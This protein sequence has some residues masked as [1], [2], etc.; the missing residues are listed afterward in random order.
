MNSIGNK[1]ENLK[2]IIRL[3]LDVIAVAETKINAS[4]PKGQL[5]FEEYHS[6]YSLDISRKI[7]VFLVYDVKAAITYLQ[8]SLKN[9]QLRIQALAFDH[10]T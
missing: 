9:F 6:R 1:F 2:K 10:I 4:F 5:F 8:V 7:Y 3:N